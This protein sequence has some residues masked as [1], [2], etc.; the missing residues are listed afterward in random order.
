MTTQE[1]AHTGLGAA[2][3]GPVPP[4]R[5]S[6]VPV[7]RQCPQCGLPGTVVGGRRSADD[8]CQRCDFPLFWAGDRVERALVDEGV[9][10]SLRRSPGTVGSAALASTPC[11]GCAELNVPSAS[12]CVRCGSGMTPPPPVVHVPPA[13]EPFTLPPLARLGAWRLLPWHVVGA[14]CG[15]AL[16][17]GAVAAWPLR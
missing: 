10:D 14:G 12:R 5:P 13:P 1:Q 3:P 17:I 15:L 4:A 9:E 16:A 2:S 7:A 8:F 11:P 6:A